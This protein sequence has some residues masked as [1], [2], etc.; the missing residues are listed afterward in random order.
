MLEEKITS[1]EEMEDPREGMKP[2]V[3]ETGKEDATELEEPIEEVLEGEDDGEGTEGTKEEEDGGEGKE[4]EGKEEKEVLTPEKDLIPKH[5]VEQRINR[6]YARLK[7]AESKN[8]APEGSTEDDGE[9]EKALT[10]KEAEAI[11]NR[12]EKEKIFIENEISVI[13]RHPN[14]LKDDGTFNL[15]DNFTK[16]FIRIGR[17]NPE[18]AMM[19][20]GSLLAEAM[21]EKELGI[22]YKR[23]KKAAVQHGKR[24]AGAH[25]STSTVS[26]KAENIVKLSPI[27]AKIAS[28]MRMTETEY[29]AYENK[30]AAGK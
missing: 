5:V 14:S 22:G 15:E 18:L 17:D 20:N 29:I 9:E 8:K 24:V 23:G 1:G 11:W 26:K 21:V 27:K 7:Q 10:A 28:R 16:A 30:I 19:P 12:K 13:K 4:E 25:T 3:E 6:M 2:K